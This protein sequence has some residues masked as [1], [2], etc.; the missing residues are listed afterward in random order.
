[1]REVAPIVRTVAM[2]TIADGEEYTSP[3]GK[4]RIHVKMPILPDDF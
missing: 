4:A 3:K 2:L 1:M